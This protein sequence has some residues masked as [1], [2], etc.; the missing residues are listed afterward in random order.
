M[1]RR[2]KKAMPILK[3]IF[4]LEREDHLFKFVIIFAE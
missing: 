1:R 4:V 3:H 2:Q